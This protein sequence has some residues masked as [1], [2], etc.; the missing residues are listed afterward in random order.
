MLFSLN[1]PEQ[2]HR[3]LSYLCLLIFSRDRYDDIPW[4]QTEIA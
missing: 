4:L 1:N 2:P 3:Y